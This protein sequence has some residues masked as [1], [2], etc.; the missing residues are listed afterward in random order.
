MALTAAADAR[1]PRAPE[2]RQLLEQYG[3]GPV[4]FTGTADALYERHVLF[5][6]VTDPAIGVLCWNSRTEAVPTELA[7]SRSVNRT[8]M[9]P[10]VGKSVAALDLSGCCRKN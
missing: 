9:T 8:T 4:Q 5:D 1:T 2:I 6:S 3:C 7:R 10:L